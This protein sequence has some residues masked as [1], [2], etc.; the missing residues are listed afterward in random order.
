MNQNAIKKTCS[1]WKSYF[2]ALKD[3]RAAPRKYRGKPRIPKYIR[4]AEA[5]AWF[6]SQTARL[7][8][9]DVL[10]F[11]GTGVTIKAGAM[12][13]RYVKTEV[14]PWAGTYRIMVTYDDTVKEV[15]VPRDPKR[16]VGIDPGLANFLATANNFGEK[17]FLIR[18]GAL[19]AA[20]QWFNKRRAHLVSELTPGEGQ[21]PF[22][23]GEPCPAYPYKKEGRLY[24]GLLL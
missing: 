17:P 1:D 7:A 24:P 9:K 18:G 11:V 16:I 5:T 12:K 22:R 2:R 8:Q 13:G 14:L 21:P 23:E 4:E 20:N 15:P 10:S 3:W 19:K 6:S